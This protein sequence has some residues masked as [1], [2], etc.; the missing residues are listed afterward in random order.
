M[1]SYRMSMVAIMVR[2]PPQAVSLK[3][4]AA[5][6]A[7]RLGK[8]GFPGMDFVRIKTPWGKAF[9]PRRQRGPGNP[10]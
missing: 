10:D 2:T 1:P 8:G 5:L 9:L 7:Q 6:R 3:A 4:T